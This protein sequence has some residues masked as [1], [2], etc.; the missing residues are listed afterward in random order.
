MTEW[1]T[2]ASATDLHHVSC[3]P[4]PQ[5]LRGHIPRVSTWDVC[6]SKV[7]MVVLLVIAV[8]AK[9]N[10]MTND[11][12]TKNPRLASPSLFELP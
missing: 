2:R 1:W 11:G 7:E 10:D 5:S 9:Q 4:I 6:Q 3:L 8:L 12:D